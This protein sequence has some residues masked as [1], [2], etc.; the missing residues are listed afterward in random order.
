[1]LGTSAPRSVAIRMTEPTEVESTATAAERAVAGC[2]LI[3][4]RSLAGAQL[5]RLPDSAVADPRSRF[6][7]S[8]VRRMHAESVP[9]DEVTFAGYVQRHA[10]L[11]AGP[12]RTM[13]GTWI[14]E[15][16]SAAPI[17]MSLS[18]YIDMVLEGAARRTVAEGA[19]K[20][21]RIADEASMADLRAV[22]DNVHSDALAALDRAV[23]R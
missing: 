1:M 21:A 16:A 4:P 11:A 15:I 9:V 22:I 14:H 18:Y 3:A 6:V 7:V 23:T 20:L 10:L 2:L 17:P 19:G 13:L 8:T 12:Q 5:D